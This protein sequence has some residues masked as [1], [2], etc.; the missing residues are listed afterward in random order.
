MSHIPVNSEI[1]RWA[2]EGLNFSRV[3]VAKK[4]NKPE[5]H[6]VAWETGNSAPTY[7]QL[8]QLASVYHRPV[9]LFFFPNPPDEESVEE[10]FRTLPY[11]ELESISPRIRLLIRKARILQINLAELFQGVIDPRRRILDDLQMDEMDNVE[12]RANQVRSYLEIDLITQKS[13]NNVRTAFQRWRSSL[14]S[15]GIFVFKDSFKEPGGSRSRYSGFCI[16][17]QKFPIIFINNNDT[18]TRQVFT[19]FHELAHLLM[20]SSEIDIRM[21]EYERHETQDNKNIEVTCNKFAGEFLVPRRDFQN[22]LDRDLINSNI[23]DFIVE[24][25]RKYHVSREAVLRKLVDCEISNPNVYDRKVSQW[26]NQTGSQQSGGG[27]YYLT[28]IAYLGDRYISAVFWNYSQRRITIEQAADYLDMKVK[29]VT[30]LEDR[31][32]KLRFSG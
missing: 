11:Q 4:M 13:W 14:E 26:S 27:N 22:Y 32:L 2:R 17:D 9:A 18:Y 5:E 8:E 1:L 23:D 20:K 15:C 31:F 7:V 10:T 21:D 19:L 16:Y 3:E 30:G 6:I 29:N 12:E 24:M 28:K 25:A